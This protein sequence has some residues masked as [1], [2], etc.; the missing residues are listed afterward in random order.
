VAVD[1]EIEALA[2]KNF[3]KGFA[4]YLKRFHQASA[5]TRKSLSRRKTTPKS[6]KP[7]KSES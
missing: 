1:N 2:L 3:A 7:Q 5:R 4:L 6:A